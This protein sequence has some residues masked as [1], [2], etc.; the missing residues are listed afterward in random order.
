MAIIAAFKDGD[1]TCYT[2]SVF[3]YDKGQRLMFLGIE[4]PSTF[5]VHLSTHKD[6]DIGTAH[7]ATLEEGLLIPDEYFAT[8]EYVYAW[9]Y[10]NGE[11]EDEGAT[12]YFVTIPVIRKPA[13]I[14]VSIG[15]G[16]KGFNLDEDHTLIVVP[17]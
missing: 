2:K 10:L 12:S 1:N 6:G 16:I 11:G 9:I 14:P 5:E 15:S 3:Q 4:L 17:K 13:S 8:G 7:K